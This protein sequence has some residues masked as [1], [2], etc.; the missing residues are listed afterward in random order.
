MISVE[1]AQE[2]IFSVQKTLLLLTLRHGAE[3]ELLKAI[4]YKWS[5][6]S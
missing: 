4:D 1:D 2:T 6:V 3:K 5:R